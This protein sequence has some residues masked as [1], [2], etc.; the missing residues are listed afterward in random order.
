MG[1]TVFL[2]FL[3]RFFQMLEYSEALF[4]I[5]DGV[6]ARVFYITMWSSEESFS[7]DV[8]VGSNVIKC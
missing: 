7:S 4:T 8:S 5:S 3:F 1:V 6:F 2:G